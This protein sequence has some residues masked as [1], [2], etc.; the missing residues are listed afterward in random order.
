MDKNIRKF[1]KVNTLPKVIKDLSVCI[2]PMV[3]MCIRHL[4]CK[5]EIHIYHNILKSFDGLKLK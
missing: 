1:K 5:N 2:R 4:L 3:C